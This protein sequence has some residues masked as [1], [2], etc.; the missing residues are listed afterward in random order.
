MGELT[1][2]QRSE[3]MA[4]AVQ[5][6]LFMKQQREDRER[7]TGVPMTPDEKR[8]FSREWDRRVDEGKKKT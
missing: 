1:E 4:L 5:R 6:G 2:E 3:L 7:T 8:T